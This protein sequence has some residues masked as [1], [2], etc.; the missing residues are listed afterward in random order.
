MEFIQKMCSV[1]LYTFDKVKA[2]IWVWDF[3][4]PN[5]KPRRK[6]CLFTGFTT[7]VRLNLDN[8]KKSV[9]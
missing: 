1:S 5:R 7:Y 9:V 4:Y 2:Q 8:N 6:T 3:Q